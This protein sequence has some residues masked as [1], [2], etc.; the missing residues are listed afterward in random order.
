MKDNKLHWT[1]FVILFKLQ[2]ESDQGLP[3]QINQFN[4]NYQDA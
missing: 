4:Q 2:V 3:H 1:K